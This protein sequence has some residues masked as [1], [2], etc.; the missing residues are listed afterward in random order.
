MKELTVFKHSYWTSPM[1]EWDNQGQPRATGISQRANGEVE[2]TSV[3]DSEIEM[4]ITINDL[5]TLFF[6]DWISMLKNTLN[7]FT[8]KTWMTIALHF[9]H[10]I[11]FFLNWYGFKKC[12][13][14]K[15]P[16]IESRIE[17]KMK[18]LY[19]NK[20]IPNFFSPKYI[21]WKRFH[22]PTI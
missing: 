1:K 11:I 7:N 20:V 14:T 9:L 18:T 4:R 8:E 21:P 19:S 22:R 10:S 16:D 12:S 17:L 15:S 6:G 13:L 3:M 2:L 5:L